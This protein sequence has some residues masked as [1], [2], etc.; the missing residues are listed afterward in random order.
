MSLHS[1]TEEKIIRTINFPDEDAD[2]ALKEATFLLDQIDLYID[3]N[4]SDKAL[5]QITQHD[6]SPGNR[7]YTIQKGSALLEVKTDFGTNIKYTG[8][9][10]EKYYCFS[11]TAS[12][13]N[14]ALDQTERVNKDIESSFR[15]I[16]GA[17]LG[18][19]A[20]IF[21]AIA[22]GGGPIILLGFSGGAAIGALLGDF[23]GQIIRKRVEHNLEQR[24]EIH[25]VEHEW[26]IL[27]QTLSIVCESDDGFAY[28]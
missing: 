22:G 3:Q 1:A 12:H 25:E 27:K 11:A 10:A 23:I 20:L 6:S 17:I 8:N 16:G 19:M 28:N 7:L 13:R 18:F 2:G 15:V 9:V 5:Y 24:G 14:T 26:T 21:A 4:F